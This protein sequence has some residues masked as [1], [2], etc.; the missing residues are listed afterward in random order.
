[1]LFMLEILGFP[2]G[3]FPFSTLPG[4]TAARIILPVTLH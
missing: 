2:E 4:E 3:C 1:L